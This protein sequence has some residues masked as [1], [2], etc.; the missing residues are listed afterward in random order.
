MW[1]VPNVGLVWIYSTRVVQKTYTMKLALEADFGLSNDLKSPVKTHLK[2]LKSVLF[3]FSH[4][5][6]NQDLQGKIGSAE[7]EFTN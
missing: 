5:Q 7:D 1:V 4:I 6:S 2:G 3:F